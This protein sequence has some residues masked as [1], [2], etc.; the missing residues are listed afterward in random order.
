MALLQK[1]GKT[2]ANNLARWILRGGDLSLTLTMIIDNNYVE[3]SYS[4]VRV[5]LTCFRREAATKSMIIVYTHTLHILVLLLQS[6]ELRLNMHATS[7]LSLHNQNY[8]AHN[9]SACLL[10]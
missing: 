5:S 3:S 7:V 6:E 10:Y 2:T 8:Y 9:D 4:P 1:L